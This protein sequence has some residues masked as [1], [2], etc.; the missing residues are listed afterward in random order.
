MQETQVLKL[1][2][3]MFDIVKHTYTAGGMR[4]DSTAK[5]ILIKDGKAFV[6]K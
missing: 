4:A 1:S 5:G 6:S 2:K 3:S